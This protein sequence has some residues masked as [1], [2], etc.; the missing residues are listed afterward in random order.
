MASRKLDDLAPEVAERAERV[1]K[2]CG[3]KPHCFT[4]DKLINIEGAQKHGWKALLYEGPQKFC[5][6]YHQL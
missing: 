5:D 3:G 4:D 2:I 6:D 1:E